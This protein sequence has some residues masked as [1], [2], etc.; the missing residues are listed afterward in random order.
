[1]SKRLGKLPCVAAAIALAASLVACGGNAGTAP[2][3]SD[4]SSQ[5]ASAN[6][7][8]ATFYQA[9]NDDGF[10]AFHDASSSTPSTF[11]VSAVFITSSG[12]NAPPDAYSSLS[13]K[14]DQ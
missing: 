10:A 8:T 4:S 3:A 11:G 1:M 12:V 14:N 13:A 6:G 5:Q 2:A 7:G 9:K